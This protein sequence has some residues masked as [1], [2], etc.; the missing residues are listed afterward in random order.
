MVRRNFR[1]LLKLLLLVMLMPFFVF[2]LQVTYI[3][4]L[5]IQ[6]YGFVDIIYHFP[7][8]YI[9]NVNKVM[10]YANRP[11]CKTCKDKP[12][13][14]A[15]KRNDRVY[16]RSQC[17]SCIRKSAGK[18]VGGITALQR[19]GYKK[20]KKCELCGFKAHRIVIASERMDEY[21]SYA[22]KMLTSGHGY[23][24]TCSA[25][26]FRQ[27]R[28]EMTECPCR[29]NDVETNLERWEKCCLNRLQDPGTKLLIR[30][31]LP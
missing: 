17:D 1:L 23:V 8:A 24:C 13:A 7:G 26:S 10:Q 29:G 30:K 22:K 15:Y 14:Y 20:H 6:S 18:K 19:S 12:R 27:Y 3:L 5:F 11:L 16:W 4:E 21:H 2:S 25:E 28:A 31:M 9:G